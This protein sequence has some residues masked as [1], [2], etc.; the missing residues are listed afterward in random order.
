[1]RILTSAPWTIDRLSVSL[2]EHLIIYPATC[3]FIILPVSLSLCQSFCLSISLSIILSV[4]L[5][6]SISLSI[7]LSVYLCQSISQSLILSVY[8]CQ[9]ISLSIILSICLWQSVSLS[10]RT[11]LLR[12]QGLL[13]EEDREGA[14][15][16]LHVHF[17]PQH[18]AHE[19]LVQP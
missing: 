8:F 2:S 14:D 3:S 12:L 18:I 6:Q 16:K 19:D 4:Y 17:L 1:M 5:C 11:D 10:T 15:V 9:S 13:L 7:I